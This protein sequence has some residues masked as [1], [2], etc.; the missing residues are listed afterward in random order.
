MEKFENEKGRI[1]SKEIGEKI[2][3]LRNFK[4]WS[5]QELADKLE[6]KGFKMNPSSIHRIEIAERD[7]IDVFLL[8]KLSEIFNY[9]LLSILKEKSEK[10]KISEQENV[11]ELKNETPKTVTLPVYGMA[12]AGNGALDYDVTM[13][14]FIL[15]SDFEV[16]AN[17]FII[18]V[19]GDS[20]EPIF[21]DGDRI[22]V[23]TSKCRE[24][25]FLADY[26]VVVQIN[27]ER[28]VK[29]VKFNNYKPEFHSLNQMYN[30]IKI[31]N[32][33]EIFCVGVVTETLKRKI[34]K[35]KL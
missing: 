19:D 17:S 15:P 21:W 33:D 25:Q 7:K 5:L 1:T 6:T 22:L 27:D 12:S 32:G 20:M 35:I 14:E 31:T 34:G 8:V 29:L 30:P 9:D 23:D 26:P 16:P 13:E 2:K 28:F 18:G 11:K 4:K 10:I 24:W 3:E